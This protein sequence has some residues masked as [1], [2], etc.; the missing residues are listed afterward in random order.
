M[1]A[2]DGYW[3]TDTGRKDW[4]GCPPKAAPR[5]VATAFIIILNAFIMI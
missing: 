5:S 1:S 4:D 2:Q 3:G